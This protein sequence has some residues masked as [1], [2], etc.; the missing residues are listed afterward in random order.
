MHSVDEQTEILQKR[1]AEYADS[2]AKAFRDVEMRAAEKKAFD[3]PLV[4]SKED[5][6][7]T[8]KTLTNDTSVLQSGLK[9]VPE[10]PLSMQISH[11]T[12]VGLAILPDDIEPGFLF[13]CVA[14]SESDIEKYF[15]EFSDELL[16]NAH[17][18]WG[19]FSSVPL[20]CVSM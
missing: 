1:L 8:T 9:S 20:I 14:N 3:W 6:A 5:L 10:V 2:R 13:V 7:E 19:T 11:Q 17:P 16:D 4:E 18:E 15:H 12:F